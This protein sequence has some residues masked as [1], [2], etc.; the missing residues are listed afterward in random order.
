M[1]LYSLFCGIPSGNEPSEPSSIPWTQ[2]CICISS[3]LNPD[4]S[5]ISRLI[6]LSCSLSRYSSLLGIELIITGFSLSN[7]RLELLEFV[8]TSKDW[9]LL[10]SIEMFKNP[11]TSLGKVHDIISV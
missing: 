6:S 7:I 9:S 4:T 1:S 5:P 2:I 10:A 3:I 11:E 8:V